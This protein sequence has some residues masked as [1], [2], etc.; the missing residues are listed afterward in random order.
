MNPQTLFLIFFAISLVSGLLTFMAFPFFRVRKD[1]RLYIWMIC[2]LLYSIGSSVI[3]FQ[4]LNVS[5]L[6]PFDASN[7]VILIA[8]LLRFY[9]VIGY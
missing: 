2:N 7:K 5:G 8:Q 4:L 3:A 6:S 9:S 1:S